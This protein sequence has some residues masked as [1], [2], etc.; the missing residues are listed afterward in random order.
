MNQH[1]RSAGY[2]ESAANT[3]DSAFMSSSLASRQDQKLLNLVG[4]VDVARGPTR[5]V[6]KI[7]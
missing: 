3:Q 4:C 7:F 6:Y 5:R 1:Q 2:S